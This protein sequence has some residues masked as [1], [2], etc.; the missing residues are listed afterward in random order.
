MEYQRKQV[1]G[2]P[3]YEVD[4]VGNVFSTKGLTERKLS[5]RPNTSGYIQVKLYKHDTPGEYKQLLIHRIMYETFV[6]DIPEGDT[7]DHIDH[8]ITNN[9][10]ENFQVLSHSDNIKKSWDRRGRSKVKPIIKDWL[11]RGYDYQFISDNLGVSIPYISLIKN[12]KR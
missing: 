12:G 4:T 5:T 11:Q 7:V 10:L 1:K 9:V 2:F 3:D 8:D 6:G